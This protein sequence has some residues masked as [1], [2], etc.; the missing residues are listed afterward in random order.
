MRL[1][2]L[3]LFAGCALF[4]VAV[5]TIGG[6]P[7]VTSTEL[8]TS[9]FSGDNPALTPYL[10]TE[11][12]IKI[13]TPGLAEGFESRRVDTLQ[14]GQ[15][16]TR[17]VLHYLPCAGSLRNYDSQ[18]RD[19]V[20]RLFAGKAIS[21]LLTVRASLPSPAIATVNPIATISH[22]S[23]RKTGEAFSTEVSNQLWLTPYF[24][25][26][27]P[28]NVGIDFSLNAATEYKTSVAGDALD[29]IKRASGL[30]APTSALVTDVNKDRFNEAASFVD[31]SIN[32]FL[33]QSVLER[34]KDDYPVVGGEKN[35][36]A[37]ALSLPAMNKT[38]GNNATVGV[39]VVSTDRI[40]SSVFY[41]AVTGGKL[42][43]K[44][45]SAA[46]ILNFEVGAGISL[47]QSLASRAQLNQARDEFLHSEDEINSTGDTETK[48]EWNVA[49]R[50]LCSAIENEAQAIGL[51]P[52]DIGAVLWAYA[53]TLPLEEG[54]LNAYFRACGA[55][56]YYP[57]GDSR[58]D[59]DRDRDRG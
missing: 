34:R 32:S 49:A 2:H 57:D 47:R 37:V 22:D 9:T 6:P 3:R 21:K 19:W 12:H 56:P 46:S 55:H 29:L 18:R 27:G 42:E 48:K 30:I 16:Y 45:L 58:F 50:G 5:P 36:V 14:Q 4:A 41:L 44:N 40:I 23:G 11:R 35:L 38:L 43:T 20:K 13:D 51:V 33:K 26:N 1:Y 8:C 54:H 10:R 39:W 52:M 28:T 15:G 53:D 31:T 25:L 17:F 59:R 24:R 7:L